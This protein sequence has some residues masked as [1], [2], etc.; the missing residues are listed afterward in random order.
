MTDLIASFSSQSYFAIEAVNEIAD[1]GIKL[2]KINRFLEKSLENK[3][4]L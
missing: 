4:K 1:F 2:F 3:F